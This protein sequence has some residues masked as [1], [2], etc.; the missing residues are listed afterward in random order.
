[1][2]KT[3][4]FHD[5]QIIGLLY[6]KPEGTLLVQVKLADTTKKLI[7]FINV[8][9]WDLSPFEEQNILFDIHEYT[10]VNLPA[11]IKKDFEVPDQYIDLV[12][13]E[14]RKLYYIEPSVGLGGYIIAEK[15]LAY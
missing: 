3:F 2:N 6:E 7:K 13:A 14:K 5:A 1:M 8:D 11:W 15:L 12:N 9:G 10:K 4:S